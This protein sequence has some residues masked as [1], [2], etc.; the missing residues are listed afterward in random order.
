MKLKY[1]LPDWEDR[2]DPDFNFIKDTYS[3]KHKDNPYEHDVYVHQLL[4]EPP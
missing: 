1:F 4:Y 2:L 3:K